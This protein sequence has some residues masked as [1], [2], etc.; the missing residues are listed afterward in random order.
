MIKKNILFIC[1]VLFISIFVFACEND[2]STQESGDIHDFIREVGDLQRQGRQLVLILNGQSEVIT[3]KGV[4]YSPIAI[5]ADFG[6]QNIGDIFSNNGN[7]A[8]WEPVWQRDLVKIRE[9]GANTIRLYSMWP[10][11]PFWQG[12]GIFSPIPPPE[13]S[14]EFRDHTKFLDMVLQTNPGDPLICAFVAYP[15]RSEIFQY[16]NCNDNACG[17]STADPSEIV[18]TDLG[19]EFRRTG[20]QT[21]QDQDRVAYT[22]LAEQ[23]KDN[24]TVWGFVIG[25]E[26]N[27]NIR[28]SDPEYWNYIDSVAEDIKQIAPLKET[29]V[30][31]LD[32]SMITIPLAK[33]LGPSMCAI[34]DQ[35]G[36][37]TVG[38]D[39]CT[40]DSDC[41]SPDSICEEMPNIDIWGINSFR[42][43]QTQGFDTLFRDYHIASRKP[44]I[45]TEFGPS[46][47]T[48]DGGSCATTAV[49]L[50]NNA[51]AQADYLEVHWNDIRR[52]TLMGDETVPPSEVA[53]G[54]IVFEW[55]DEWWK[56]GTP[57][58]H[59]GG[60]EPNNSFPGGCADE[61]WFGI[62]AVDL[63]RNSPSDFPSPFVPDQLN[64]RDAFERMKNIWTGN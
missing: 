6:D 8:F 47:S 55:T 32:D 42:G 58:V 57:G 48:R 38:T 63:K 11:D 4:A 33:Q 15:V 20:N 22:T 26:L 18:T 49:E 41:N 46:A 30:T 27:N 3:V 40:S 59:N 13:G 52:T 23:L 45:V 36:T 24:N 25:N 61:E 2:D 9:M 43:T 5:G 19:E 17:C 21:V 7:D 28:R 31:L 1:F 60:T 14:D 53:S 50:P 12:D 54:G 10:W 37:I 56:A 39:P 64:P 35:D 51:E 44:F 16:C 34:V 62:N 29:M